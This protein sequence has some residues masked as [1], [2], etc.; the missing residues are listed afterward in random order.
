VASGPLVP[1][2]QEK[3]PWP[4]FSQLLLLGDEIVT[5]G[6]AKAGSAKASASKNAAAQSIPGRFNMGFPYEMKDG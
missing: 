1:H 3:S 5:E 4:T 2:E 6:S